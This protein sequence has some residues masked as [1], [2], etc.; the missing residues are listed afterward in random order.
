MH[1]CARGVRLVSAEHRVIDARSTVAATRFP[2]LP[3]EMLLALLT[4]HP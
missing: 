1:G 4:F 3:G 2:H